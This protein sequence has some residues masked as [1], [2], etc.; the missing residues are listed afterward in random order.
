MK[1]LDFPLLADE[2]AHL[3]VIS[4]LL[5]F[6][7]LLSSCSP[8]PRVETPTAVPSITPTTT[9]TPLP[10]S[11]FAP[12]PIPIPK[13]LLDQK[14][15]L[16]Q[17]GFV[18]GNGEITQQDQAGKVWQVIKFNS[19]GS[20][21][22]RS[23]DNNYKSSEASLTPEEVANLFVDPLNAGHDPIFAITDKD[24]GKVSLMFLPNIDNNPSTEAGWVA[25]LDISQDSDNP[26]HVDSAAAFHTRHVYYSAMLGA[27][28]EPWPEDF[29]TSKFIIGGGAS[30]GKYQG[31]DIKIAFS[32]VWTIGFNKNDKRVHNDVTIKRILGYIQFD[33]HGIT[34]KVRLDEVKINGEGEGLLFPFGF[35]GDSLNYGVIT[36]GVSHLNLRIEVFEFCSSVRCCKLP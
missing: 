34:N 15:L 21:S 27:G 2:N 30:V 4:F 16:E 31:N 12:T 1:A 8:E 23:L 14:G 18:F 3:K 7:L 35:S 24:T 9:A 13:N 33:L 26:T 29:P 5:V 11:T 6:W 22:I 10:T 32:H 36:S 20:G 19:D 17:A 28:A 25:P